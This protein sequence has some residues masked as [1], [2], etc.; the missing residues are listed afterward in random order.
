MG[1]YRRL[2]EGELARLG[3]DELVARIAAAREAND[4]V[5]AKAAA[6][7]LA[8]GFEQLIKARVACRVPYEDVDDVAQEALANA[9]K[10][11]RAK[12]VGLTLSY[13]EDLVLLD[14]RDDGV[15]FSLEEMKTNGLQNTGHGYGLHLMEQRLKQVAGR[16]QIE[17]A[18]GDGTAVNASVPAIPAEEGYRAWQK[19]SGS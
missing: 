9:A 10:H 4:P 11:S 14:V 18:P 16:L 6:A 19:P 3:D 5:G 7:H 1:D 8:W 17:S 12:R 13:L 2:S 15:G